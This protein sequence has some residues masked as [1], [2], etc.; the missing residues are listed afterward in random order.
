MRRQRPVAAGLREGALEALQSSASTTE[1]ISCLDIGSD[2]GL[3]ATGDGLARIGVFYN[4]LCFHLVRSQGMRFL[5]VRIMGTPFRIFI[6]A[7]SGEFATA[8]AAVASDLR[9]RGLE[10]K[11]QHDFRQETDTDTTLSKLER[12]IRGC[13]AVVALIGK[14]SGAM[15]P[16]AAAAPFAH[17]LPPGFSEASFTQWEILFAR[18]H[19]RR[20]SLY[21]AVSEW[22][23][24]EPAVPDD[25]TELQAAFRVYLFDC[26]GLDRHEALTG[27]DAL[28][29]A[30]LR[31]DWPVKR[32][33]T[34]SDKL[35]RMLPGISS[36]LVGIFFGTLFCWL[37]ASLHYFWFGFA[38]SEWIGPDAALLLLPLSALAG[39]YLGWRRSRFRKGAFHRPPTQ[40]SDHP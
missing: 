24:D 23:S 39:G 8:R 30:M 34:F 10:V 6:S 40:V 3:K 17:M 29:R 19:Q 20:L 27:V 33:A 22:N 37:L 2:A 38:V 9:A 31:E 32:E 12:Y 25:R 13:D 14:Q 4:C 15:P 36:S 11:V 35:A 21:V 5:Y 26:L 16:R 7:V 28:C 18:Y 1:E